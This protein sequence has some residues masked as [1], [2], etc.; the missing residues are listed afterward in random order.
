MKNSEC[1]RFERMPGWA[2]QVRG[3][4]ARTMVESI[5]LSLEAGWCEMLRQVER[6]KLT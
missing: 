6:E 1:A 5:M 2:V 3:R 4:S